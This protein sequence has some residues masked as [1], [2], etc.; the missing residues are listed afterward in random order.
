[1]S[2]KSIMQ[3]ATEIYILMF[4][5]VHLLFVGTSGYAHI[6]D[7]KKATFCIISILYFLCAIFCLHIYIHNK[8]N[9]KEYIG[10]HLSPVRICVVLYMVFTLISGI[11]SVHFPDTIFGISRFEGIFTIC[12]YGFSF[13][14]ISLFPCEKKYLLYVFSVCVTLFSLLCTIQLLGHNPLG[15]YPLGTD[16]YDAGIKYTTAFIGTIGN[17]NLSG[18]FIC[19][20]L[21]ILSVILIK[22]NSRLRFLL[23]APIIMLLFVSVRINIDSTVLALTATAILLLPLIFDFSKK[24]TIIYFC[25]LI[26]LFGLFLISIYA[27]PPQSGFL[28][29]A[30]EILHG[31]ISDSFGSG[32]IRIWKNVLSEIPDSPIIGKG[33][34]TMRRANFEPFSRYYPALGKVKTTSIDVAHN[35]LLNVLY[36]QGILGL[37]AYLGFIFC[38]IKSFWKCRQN[39]LVSALG[40][41]FICY[42]IQSLFTFSMCITAP[43]FWICAGLICGIEAKERKT[44]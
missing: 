8:R 41:A 7:A 6:F 44:Q 37:T 43:C 30:S 5:S 22:A 31:N 27:F 32:R 36:H 24:A 20:A 42:L 21:P 35:E 39:T 25:I 14:L 17:A 11:F 38:T 3:K 16:F 28:H 13:I 2:A 1:M 12:C 34:D 26:V 33:P 40:V 9:I 19:L 29:E 23:I 4:A 10:R 15:L 18:A